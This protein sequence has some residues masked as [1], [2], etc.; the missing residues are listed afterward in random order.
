MFDKA[1]IQAVVNE[2][3]LSVIQSESEVRSKHKRIKIGFE[4]IV[5]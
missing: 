1:A 5:F 3:R 4:I 2:Y